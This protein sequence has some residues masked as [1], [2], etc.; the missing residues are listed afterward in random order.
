MPSGPATPLRPRGLARQAHRM[1]D[2]SQAY[3]VVRGQSFNLF[4]AF[5]A[6]PLNAPLPL[7][8]RS[9]SAVRTSTLIG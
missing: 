2:R 3:L 6:A 4:S 9:V 1:F 7:T 5:R 8:T